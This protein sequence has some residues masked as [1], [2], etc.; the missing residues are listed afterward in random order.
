ME[1]AESLSFP[2]VPGSGGRGLSLH[3]EIL[4]GAKRFN[5]NYLTFRLSFVIGFSILIPT[6]SCHHTLLT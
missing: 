4:V 3:N 2:T 6:P 1:K 5:C